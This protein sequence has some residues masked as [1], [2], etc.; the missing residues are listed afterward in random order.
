MG[1]ASGSSLTSVKLPYWGPRPAGKASSSGTYG[2]SGQ[3]GQISPR[4]RGKMFQRAGATAEK[5]L[6]RD[7]W[8]S[9]TKGVCSIPT[10]LAW[11][12]QS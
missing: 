9:L 8:N 12:G 10:L 2:R 11:V 5:A 7:C 4:G 1:S 6:L 3:W